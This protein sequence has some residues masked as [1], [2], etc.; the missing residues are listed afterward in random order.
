[1][2][3]LKKY[4]QILLATFGSLA[5]LGLVFLLLFLMVEFFE[6]WNRDRN[7]YQDNDLVVA[8]TLN[9]TQDTLKT[10]GLVY[11]MPV[12]LDTLPQIHIITV[13][14][15]TLETPQEVYASEN[16]MYDI[17]MTRRGRIKSAKIGYRR[18]GD[19]NNLILFD[20]IRDTKNPIF[21]FKCMV[22]SF[23]FWKVNNTSY[24]II[25]GTSIDSNKD[26][27][28][29]YSDLADLYIYEIGSKSIQKLRV[30][31]HGFISYKIIYDSD[32]LIIQYGED[33]NKNGEY[34]SYV[35][36]NILKH[37]SLETKKISPFIS[38]QLMNQ[39]ENNIQ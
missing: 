22:S 39:L 36:P 2:E 25:V 16:A 37:Y 4:N 8:P 17:P 32:E 38:T 7:R 6:D 11:S 31:N 19:F 24:L 29:N 10:Q 14:Q 12:L 27:K 28:L 5:V 34:E 1:M 30:D 9:T 35:E 13:S 15:V 20:G 3:K 33:I 23:Q 26:N 18:N 21:D